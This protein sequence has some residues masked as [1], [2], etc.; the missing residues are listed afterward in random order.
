MTMTS[1]TRTR[2]MRIGGTLVLA[3][4][5]SAFASGPALAAAK[6]AAKSTPVTVT[7]DVD[8]RVALNVAG[9]SQVDTFK[10]A[11]DYR[12]PSFPVNAAR[13]V[14][15]VPAGAVG[16]ATHMTDDSC[17]HT[18]SSGSGTPVIGPNDGV[19]FYQES[20]TGRKWMFVWLGSVAGAY[21]VSTVKDCV[22]RIPVGQPTSFAMPLNENAFPGCATKLEYKGIRVY[23]SPKNPSTYSLNC[24]VEVPDPSNPSAPP[25]QVAI[26]VV[27]T[28]K[29]TPKFQ[30]SSR[31]G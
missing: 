14:A 5:T 2:R 4:A 24:S 7:M 28:I 13:T 9:G 16:S 27:A 21:T 12:V 26:K 1:L 30:P 31:G 17:F 10:L 20:G 8:V 19:Q 6:K 29:G 11:G 22:Q 18:E 23:Q 25:A 15:W 3:V